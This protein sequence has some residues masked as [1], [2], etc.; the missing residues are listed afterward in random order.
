LIKVKEIFYKIKRI[1]VFKILKIIENYKGIDTV[2]YVN[3]E[4]LGFSKDTSYRYEYSKKKYLWQVLKESNITKNDSII[5]VGS[6]KGSALI[7]FS[8]YQ[9]KKVAGV[10]LSKTLH[11]ICKNNLKVLK[12]SNVNLYCTNA[13]DFDKYYEYNYIYFY[14]PFPEIIFEEV[15]NR[16]I[17]SIKINKRIIYIIYKNPTCHETIMKSKSFDLVKIYKNKNRMFPLLDTIYLYK[18]VL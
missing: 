17:N 11:D 16:L 6:G 8:K 10:E 3:I 14:N 4:E 15:L 18:S 13:V 7:E 5:D 9:F 12:I 1:L 2:K